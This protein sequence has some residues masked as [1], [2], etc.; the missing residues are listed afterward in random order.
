MKNG[1]EVFVFQRNKEEK[2]TNINLLCSVYAKRRTEFIYPQMTQIYTDKGTS[3]DWHLRSSVLT[4][5]KFCLD[6][7]VSCV[8][9]GF[10]WCF[11]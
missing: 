5:D 1:H 11:F 9:V 8:L 7:V 4:V 6:S 2:S 10:E 3:A